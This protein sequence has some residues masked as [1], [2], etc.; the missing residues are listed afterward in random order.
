MKLVSL[1]G[2]HSTAKEPPCLETKAETPWLLQSSARFA[3][4][5]EYSEHDEVPRL[6]LLIWS[7]ADKGG[8]ARLA[9]AYQAHILHVS[10]F[11]DAGE[12]RIYLERLVHTLTTKRSLLKWRAF[13][14]VN[15]ISGLH[16]LPAKISRPIQASAKPHLGYIFTGQGAQYASMGIDLLDFPIFL[17]SIR[18]SEVYL[19]ELGCP[20]QLTGTSL[21]IRPISNVISKQE[22][23]QN[24]R[25]AF[26]KQRCF[27]YRQSRI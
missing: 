12:A 2:F 24:S 20:W 23:S 4:S 15:S 13:V 6:K 1:E 10:P 21:D 27:K 18:Q 25:G 14:V 9:E 22:F 17:K 26:K 8:L 5:S 11:L 7:A 16:D 19:A 3:P